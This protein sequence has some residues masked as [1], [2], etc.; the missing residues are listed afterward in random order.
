MT[1]LFE[2]IPTKYIKQNKKLQKIKEK[3]VEING[4]E[5]PPTKHNLDVWNEYKKTENEKILK[6]LSTVMLDL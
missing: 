2:K 3:T 4:K 5:Y 6:G 1:K